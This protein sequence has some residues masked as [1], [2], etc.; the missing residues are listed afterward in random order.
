MQYQAHGFVRELISIAI[1]AVLKLS[2]QRQ[3]SGTH[4]DMESVKP[5]A[6]ADID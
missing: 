1:Q 6:A 3:L 5:M 2:S 4:P